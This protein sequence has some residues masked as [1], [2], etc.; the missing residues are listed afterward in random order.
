MQQENNLRQYREITLFSELD[1][2]KSV[3]SQIYCLILSSLDYSILKEEK[4]SI[5][6][7]IKISFSFNL[8]LII[9]YILEKNVGNPSPGS[10]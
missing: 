6:K 7:K 9:L 8:G 2:F 5:I 3:I 4:P 10:R 1:S